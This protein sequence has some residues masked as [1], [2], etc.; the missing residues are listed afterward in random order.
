MRCSERFDYI[1]LCENFIV[2]LRYSDDFVGNFDFE[3]RDFEN[4]GKWG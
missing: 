2:Q 4:G 1:D 3:T